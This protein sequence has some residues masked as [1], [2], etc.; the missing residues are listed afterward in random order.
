MRGSVLAG[1]AMSLS[2]TEETLRCDRSDIE[3]EVELGGE[4][5]MEAK[6]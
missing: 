1:L 6:D 2:D 3:A 4:L 5:A